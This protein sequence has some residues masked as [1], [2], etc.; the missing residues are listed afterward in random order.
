VQGDQMSLSEK[1][2][3]CSPGH[4][5]TKLLIFLK[6]EQIVVSGP[7]RLKGFKAL[8]T[9]LPLLIDQKLIDRQLI[10]FHKKTID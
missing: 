3:K 9:V 8:G 5:F 6:M 1:R 10:D 2:P 7:A 4:F